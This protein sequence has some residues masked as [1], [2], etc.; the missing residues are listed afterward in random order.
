MTNDI[1]MEL[2]PLFNPRSVAVIGASNNWSKWGF[3]T[4]TSVLNGFKGKVYPVNKSEEIVVGRRAYKTILDVPD[5]EPV[6][7]AIF[8]IPAPAIPKVMEDCVKKGVKAGVII[9]AGFAETGKEGRKLQD[10]VLRIAQRGNLRFIGPN[11]MGYYSASSNLRAFMFPIP[12]LSGPIGFVT[13]GGNVGGAVV[14]AATNR[15]IGF[16]RYIS[17]GCTADI[18]IEEYIE[19]FGD[20]PE[21]KI[22]LAYIEGLN[23]GE[24]FVEK[25]SKVTKKKPVIALKPGRTTAA[26]EAILS[27]SGAIAG[28]SDIWDSAFKKAGVIRAESPD[29]LLDIA[30]G[31]LTQPLPGGKNVAIMTPGGSYGVLCADAC[32]SLGLNVVKLSDE[33][34]A[35]FDKIFPPRW[36]HGNPV[37]PAGDRNFTAYLKAPEM[38]LKLDEVDSLI[39]MGF[40]GF[41]SFPSL[42]SSMN[43]KFSRMFKKML[44]PLIGIEKV[45]KK[46]SS[47]DGA[48]QT[49]RINKFIHSLLFIF[50]SVF[51]TSK[52]EE[53]EDFARQ[54]T[55]LITSEFVDPSILYTFSQLVNVADLNDI[56][57]QMVERLLDSFQPLLE[58]LIIKWM[59][60]HKKP[61]ITTNFTEE[62]TSLKGGTFY[63]FSSGKKAALVLSKLVEYSEYLKRG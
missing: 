21:I 10:E 48:S 57:D 41:S 28:S 46:D 1:T 12:I 23:D 44:T 11:C 17:C 4:F 50:F 2:A 59:H 51:G 43:H 20:D 32:A 45:K 15:N 5:D 29:E 33:T 7:L 36:S 61:I 19:C 47:S 22:I 38:L 52:K 3:S 27:H 6:D 16:H 58:A 55:S 42:V 13:Q 14:G 49:S 35:T 8:V 62:P 63:S 40:D 34:I 31:F 60:E 54:L 39:F 30:V 37:D 56:D 18:Q 25:V 26:A 53:V 9:S 24:R